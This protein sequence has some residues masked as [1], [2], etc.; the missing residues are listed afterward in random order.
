[1]AD[2]A[3]RREVL[4][5]KQVRAL[6][7]MYL[8]RRSDLTVEE[9]RGDLGL[10]LFVRLAPGG[11]Q[12]VRQFGVEL[13]GVFSSVT[14]VHADKVLRRSVREAQGYGPFGFPVCLFFFTME[15]NQGWYTWVAE[16]VVQSG[17][18][19][20][21]A[22]EE[23]DCRPLHKGALDEIVARVNLWYDA[24]FQNLALDTAHDAKPG[25]K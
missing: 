23:A 3:A 7:T 4:I 25:R 20:L 15:N 12:G 17:K 14:K 21:R 16:P 24:F 13:R 11:G 10:D 6:A 9:A 2:K 19:L 8:T 1:M 18:A 5:A 22:H